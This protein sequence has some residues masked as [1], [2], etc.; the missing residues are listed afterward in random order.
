MMPAPLRT[1]LLAAAL[2]TPR[3]AAAAG[4]VDYGYKPADPKATVISADG[5]CR[6]SVL[7]DRLIRLEFS[8]TKEFDERQSLFVTNRALSVPKFSSAQDSVV[9]DALTIT[10]KSTAGPPPVASCEGMQ[11]YDG[12]KPKV[13]SASAPYGINATR[14]G[15]CAACK[16]AADCNVWVSEASAEAIDNCYLL[17]SSGPPMKAVARTV[18]G[19]F[20]GS[21]FSAGAVR[22]QSKS[23]GT[24]SGPEFD[25]SFG[26]MDSG[27]LLG[28]ARSLDGVTG[29]I[30]LNC[31][32]PE[33]PDPEGPPCLCPDASYSQACCT[34]GVPKYCNFGPL[35]RDGWA[36]LDDSANARLDPALQWIENPANA[37]NSS[38]TGRGGY[39]DLYFF[40]YGHDYKAAMRAFTA[41]ASPAPMPPR[42]VLG[43]WWS[44]YWPY[45]TED[46]EDIARSYGL[47]STPLDV[48]VSDMAWHYHGEAP[49]KWGG[50]SWGPQ[51]FPEPAHYLQTIAAAGLNTTLN[52]HLDA[53]EP[54]PVTDQAAYTR[55]VAQLGLPVGT[56]V[57]IPGPHA[58]AAYKA[59]V[60]QLLSSSKTFA[61]AYLDL[62]D[63]MG[64]NFWW[65]D[66]EPRWVSR[67]LYEHSEQRMQRGLAFGRWG[68]LGSHR[69][70]QKMGCH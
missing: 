30:D 54:P 68:G 22:V 25:W 47:H 7:T 45:T 37:S 26:D 12:S 48:L 11:G 57:T 9:T 14:A 29:S 58:P 50:Y 66:D 19:T 33:H 4:P 53:V 21:G 65:L 40:G 15:C 28:T 46:L 27:N 35:S 44:R 8:E 49:V 13:R 62:L 20:G 3:G 67:I 17:A 64:T 43:V 34:K 52:L 32:G 42:F 1:L 6:I 16:A 24:Y 39:S 2:S 51:L 31:S 36:V 70:G 69:C 41:V 55:F 63:H 10:Y 56:N 38:S 59:S 5:K 23:G 60:K 61:M 18:G